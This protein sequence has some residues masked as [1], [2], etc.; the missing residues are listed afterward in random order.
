MYSVYLN[1]HIILLLSPCTTH[2]HLELPKKFCTSSLTLTRKPFT[3]KID[4]TAHHSILLSVMPGAKLF[5]QLFVFYS[6][7]TR[8]LSIHLPMA[9]RFPSASCVSTRRLSRA[10]T[11]SAM[12]SAS[13]FSAVLNICWQRIQIRLL[14]SSLRSS[15]S[16]TGLVNGPLSCHRC[17][18]Y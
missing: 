12:R 10:T 9:G 14:T 17:R 2:V 13:P 8:T 4:V 7:S 3:P 15:R 5:L 16:P 1:K 6:V 18:S 11:K